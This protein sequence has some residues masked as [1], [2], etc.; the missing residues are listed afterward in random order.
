MTESTAT[1]FMVDDDEGVRRA[2]TRL[3]R[4]V[5]YNVESFATAADFLQC[6]KCVDGPSCLVLDVGLPDTNGLELQLLLNAQNV[7]MPIVFLSGEG[8]IAMTVR[9]MKAGATDFL[10]KPVG[11]DAL[12]CA[13]G[14]A[15][16]RS[17]EAMTRRVETDSLCARMARLTPR[18][19][20]VLSLLLEGRMNKQVACD[21]GIAEKTIKVHRARVMEKME[22]RTLVELVRVT[23]K[24]L[25]VSVI[26]STLF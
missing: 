11:E 6:T 25:N 13:I 20:E 1:I 23:D 21:L 18:E 10:T 12:L 19:K 22:I 7:I 2:V 4:S 17:A 16:Q 26:S 14:K 5:G 9:A 8:D 15:L 3:I 24:V